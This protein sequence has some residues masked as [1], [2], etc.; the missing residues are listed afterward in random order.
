MDMI[1]TGQRLKTLRED[2]KKKE[3]GWSQPDFAKKLNEYVENDLGGE[4]GKVTVSQLERGV[5][6]L[7]L[8]MALAYSEI[9]GVTLDYICGK[10]PDPQPVNKDI[11][12]ITTLSDD[13]IYILEALKERYETELKYQKTAK[14]INLLLESEPDHYIFD[15][16]AGYL[17]DEYEPLP[18]AKRHY[19]NDKDHVYVKDKN[20]GA[21]HLID[22]SI[23]PSAYLITMQQ[24]LSN[25]RQN[26]I[27]EASSNG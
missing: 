26:A 17:Y 9:F 14:A 22:V 7:T 27:R 8:E 3:A 12:N 25:L 4:N 2:K 16:I 21:T 10:S 15:L 19:N 1:A 23:L 24:R 13:A 5:R 18:L 6:N 20:T 11:R